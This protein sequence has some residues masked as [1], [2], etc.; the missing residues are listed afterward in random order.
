[1]N[2]NDFN[3]LA[4]EF[5]NLSVSVPATP[6][7]M[8]RQQDLKR[9]KQTSKDVLKNILKFTGLAIKYAIVYIPV[10]VLLVYVGYFLIQTYLVASGLTFLHKYD[11]IA[12]SVT[13]LQQTLPYPFK[14]EGDGWTT[15]GKW[16]V[17]FVG[18]GLLQ[19]F[20]PIILLGIQTN[21][22]KEYVDEDYNG[23]E[24]IYEEYDDTTDKTEIIY[25]INRKS[26][27]FDW[28]MVFW[29]YVMCIPMGAFITTWFIP[30]FFNNLCFGLV[31]LL[32]IPFVLAKLGI[33]FGGGDGYADSSNSVQTERPSKSY[34]KLS[35]TNTNVRET[36]KSIETCKFEQI[37]IQGNGVSATRQVYRD[38][39]RQGYGSGFFAIGKLV[40]A[41]PD[42]IVVENFG[43]LE[44]YEPNNG[45][46]ISST[47]IT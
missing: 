22:Y 42:A 45:F 27:C 41:S 31:C 43:K 2:Y 19:V 34:T 10:V 1:M 5:K 28:R 9:L 29:S 44:T 11:F 14:P 7:E 38:G 17:Y 46:R 36:H 35:N 30:K 18:L 13:F 8:K 32:I 3:K 21:D 37:K 33:S 20:V 15:F 24:Q 40:S 25:Y 16:L 23:P 26:H 39:Q 12:N 6:Q 4:E 47:P